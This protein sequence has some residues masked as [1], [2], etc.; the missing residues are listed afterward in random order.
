MRNWTSVL[1][2]K[3]I[4][5]ACF[6]LCFF[7]AISAQNLVN[8]VDG[9]WKKTIANQKLGFSYRYDY[10]GKLPANTATNVEMHVSPENQQNAIAR[11]VWGH[12]NPLSLRNGKTQFGYE[13]VLPG[14]GL[15]ASEA[16]FRADYCRKNANSLLTDEQ[17]LLFDSLLTPF[18]KSL[19]KATASYDEC[20]AW[21]QQV[22]K[23]FPGWVSLGN[24]GTGDIGRPIYV[25]RIDLDRTRVVDRFGNSLGIIDD[26]EYQKRR[27]F[28]TTHTG[29]EIARKQVIRLLVNNNI[30][31][32][33][34]EG[35]D[36]SML[37]VRDMLFFPGKYAPE[38]ADLQIHVVCQYNVD[39]T[40]NRGRMSR[41]NQNG[42]EEYGFRGNAQNLDLNRDFV[43]MDSKNA[44]ALVAYMSIHDFDFFIDN[45]TSNGAD[46]Q[47]VLT[48]FHTR[49]EKFYHPRRT[50][51]EPIETELAKR[52]KQHAWITSPY[53]ETVSS[54]PDSGIHAF[55]ETGR[56]ATGFAALHG[57]VGYTVETHMW[58][59]FDQRV[60]GTLAFLEEFVH[61]IMHFQYPN[62]DHYTFQNNG[63]IVPN[64]SGRLQPGDKI[65]LHFELDKTRWDSIEFY[66]YTAKNKVSEVTGLARMY[67]DLGSPWKKKIKYYRYFRPT[68]EVIVPKV[69]I[70][71]FAY[72]EVAKRL[73][74][75]GVN[76]KQLPMDTIVKVRVSYVTHFETGKSPYEKHYLHTRVAT[77]D[78]VMAIQLYKGDY[79][80]PV[81]KQAAFL[82]QV[83]EPKAP[84]SYFSWNFFDGVLQQKEW[85]SDYIFEDYA[86]VWLKQNPGKK[87][88]LERKKQLDPVFAKDAWAQLVWVYMQT[89]LYEPTHNLIP[90]YR[91]D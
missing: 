45:H 35:T 29:E 17:N 1:P 80:I 7:G 6:S 32:G 64:S 39:G 55:W 86:A 5:L 57:C 58:K 83:L 60:V 38:G 21:Y 88:E 78:T 36:A 75:N 18:E 65:A 9:V 14:V 30:H 10:K 26:S 71:P 37:L 82:T 4:L 12:Q 90:V 24:I 16:M 61:S 25:L 2:T 33:E 52:L 54:T 51:I 46:Y 47:Y 89:P 41:A 11:G 73:K 49:P 77:R 15:G 20:V 43:K 69:Y 8:G 84:D 34:P 22:A 53:V 40:L 19:G 59:P 85:F 74:W 56:Y 72:V 87:L 81:G 27:Q 62:D 13:F 3:R 76:F 31:P 91:I 68:E 70:V 44:Q 48:Y 67:Y 66:G 42:P 50:W 79:V 63:V 28:V 23:M